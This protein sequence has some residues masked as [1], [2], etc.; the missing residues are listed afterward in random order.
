MISKDMYR[1][2]KR[3]PRQPD[4]VQ[5][6]QLQKASSMDRKLLIGLLRDAH[7]QGI[8]GCSGTFENKNVGYYL[9]ESGRVAIDEYKGKRRTERRATWALIISILSFLVS[10]A[11]KLLPYVV[12]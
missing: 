10:V 11:D 8:V 1:V 2:L 5:I 7:K 6:E 9:S 4:N 3:I 12:Q